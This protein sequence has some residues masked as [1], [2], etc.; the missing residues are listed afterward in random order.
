MFHYQG[1]LFLL[2][3]RDKNNHLVQLHLYHN[4]LLLLLLCLLH[5]DELLVL[6]Y[7][8]NNNYFYAEIFNI[9]WYNPDSD[10]YGLRNRVGLSGVLEPS[11][12]KHL[13][14][15]HYSGCGQ[16]NADIIWCISCHYFRNWSGVQYAIRKL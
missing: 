4:Y 6:Q 9:T 5:T 12:A 11:R 15:V 7:Q 2:Q 13:A 14:V 10:I 1:I 3:D 16:H 8:G